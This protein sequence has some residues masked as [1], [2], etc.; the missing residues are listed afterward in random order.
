M[1]KKI[2]EVLDGILER[3]KSGDIP[4]AVACAMFPVADDIPS[5]KWSMLN[6]VIMYLS[7]TSDARGY[8]QWQKNNRYVKKGAKCFYILVPYIKKE[9]DEETGKESEVLLGFSGRP[10]FRYEDTDGEPLADLD[11]KL[12]E[13]PLI[14]RAR[15]WGISVRAVPGNFRYYGFYS[16]KRNEIAL[17]TPEEST[18]FHELSHA[19]HERIKGKLKPGQDPFEEIIAELSAHALCVLVGKQASDSI[20][21]SYRYIERYA[22]KINHSPHSACLKV[23]AETEKVLKLVLKEDLEKSQDDKPQVL[24]IGIQ[25]EPEIAELVH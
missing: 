19:A 3:F 12:P 24:D 5:S 21:N 14:E 9:I 15:K 22:R 6:R 7:G 2:K 4:D 8:R 20:G 23:M 16:S 10:V 13:L 11:L 18:F 25:K 1:N 17:A